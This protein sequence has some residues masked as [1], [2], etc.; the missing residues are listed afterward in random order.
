MSAAIDNWSLKR[1]EEKFDSSISQAGILAGNQAF[2]DTLNLDTIMSIT[3]SI[4][5]WDG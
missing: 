5:I 4:K 2:R 3:D 1:V